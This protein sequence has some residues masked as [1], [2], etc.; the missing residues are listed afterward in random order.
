[1]NCCRVVVYVL[2]EQHEMCPPHITRSMIKW[3]KYTSVPT[4]GN[5]VVRVLMFPN[6]LKSRTVHHVRYRISKRYI[7]RSGPPQLIG[8]LPMIPYRIP[9]TIKIYYEHGRIVHQTNDLSSKSLAP[10][11]MSIIPFYFSE[12]ISFE[13]YWYWKV[14]K[15]RITMYSILFRGFLQAQD[16]ITKPRSLNTRYT[17]MY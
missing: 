10:L 13:L 3:R 9:S 15:V 8:T 14:V 2:L 5:R 7:P 11:I 1:M 17:Y 12:I 4:C 6:G 16:I